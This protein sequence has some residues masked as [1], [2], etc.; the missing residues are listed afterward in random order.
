MKFVTHIDFD[1]LNSNLP[2]LKPNFNRVAILEY[3][4]Q[5]K[6]SKLKKNSIF[7]LLANERS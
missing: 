1:M 5:P 7:T 2:E 6:W 4:K 3:S